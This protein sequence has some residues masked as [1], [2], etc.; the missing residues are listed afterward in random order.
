MAIQRKKKKKMGKIR[1]TGSGSSSVE[2]S[3]FRPKQ[4]E[5]TPPCM[6]GCPQGTDIRG[7]LTT[8]QF[9]EKGEKPREETFRKAWDLL[10]DKNPLPAICGRVCPHPCESECNR[11][12]KEAPVGINRLERFVG[13][14][15]L[16]K[17]WELP[18]DGDAKFDE[19][20]SIVGSGHAG[21]SCAYHL[22]RRGYPVV[23]YES[24]EKTGGMLRYG[25]PPYRLPHDVIDAE[26]QRILDLGVELKTGVTIGRDI[27]IE[28]LKAES[29]AVFVGIGAHVGKK[30]RV[31]GED[32]ANVMSGT[33]FLRQA[34]LG[35]AP[36]VGDK[37]LVIGGGDTAIDAARVSR[38]LDADVTIVYRR[39][40]AE[41]PAI[42]EEVV[43]AE[44]EGVTMHFLAQPVKLNL[45]GD[46]AVSMTCLQ[47][48]LGEPDESGRRRP[49]QI[50]GS[51]FDIE[52]T[53]IIAAISQEPAW[54]G[55]EEVK[56]GERWLNVDDG[57]HTPM[58]NVWAGGDVIDLALVTTAIAQGRLAADT[59]HRELRA[60]AKPEAGAEKPVI[61]GDKMILSFYEE[62]ALAEADEVPPEARF[63]DP[64]REIVSTLG[65][66]AAVAEAQRCMSC[67]RCFDCG[68]CWSYCQ[69][70]A[71]VK[72]IVAGGE[73]TFKMEFCNG[74]K[75]CAEQ[76][77]CGFLEM[78]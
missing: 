1:S 19:K 49:V 24:Y 37:V 75:K 57:G 77:P 25:I 66:D 54:E 58:D 62:K 65:E 64:N 11:K 61:R 63:E 68:T 42:D 34:N 7:F 71:I 39:T 30:L 10:V 23:M 14:Y 16:D 41:M 48:E 28:D 33:E 45:E 5:K 50:E 74:C 67:G 38:R 9:G 44:E 40:R 31:D 46:Q 78:H 29:A 36:D 51:E 72:P 4:V 73:Y 60:E 21:L 22:A 32:A 47:C 2:S 15:A 56:G 18:R 26:V 52:A 76:C 53:T 70:G 27:S 8:I 59:I 17:G 69:D 20:I 35:N 6:T 55:F 43:G 13:D 12:D 3:P